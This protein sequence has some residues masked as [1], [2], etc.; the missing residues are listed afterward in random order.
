MGLKF[1]GIFGEIKTKA[2][3]ST[4]FNKGE[5]DKLALG[6][7]NDTEYTVDVVTK[8]REDGIE[9]KTINPGQQFRNGFIKPILKDFGVD[10]IEAERIN[11]YEFNKIDGL[12]EL[13]NEINFKYMETGRKLDFLP[14]EDFVGGM[15]LTDVQPFEKEYK[16]VKKSKDDPDEFVNIRKEAHRVLTAKSKTPK[17]KRKNID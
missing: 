8:R 1:D 13:Q 17:N 6:M 3:G 2:N 14:K 5:Y 7:L 12:Y 4:L 10:K 16:K 9:T 15:T 11:D